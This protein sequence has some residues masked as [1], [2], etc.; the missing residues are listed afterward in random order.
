MG[1]TIKH[2]NN[3]IIFKF[4]E[5]NKGLYIT[6]KKK[7]FFSLIEKI[8]SQQECLMNEKNEPIIEVNTSYADKLHQYPLPNKINKPKFYK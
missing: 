6:A 5:P 1:I 4:F 2:I 8:I 3:K 7:N